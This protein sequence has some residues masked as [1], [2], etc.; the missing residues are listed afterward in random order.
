MRRQVA[1][2]AGGVIG[3][4]SS[5]GGATSGAP[6]PGST[7]ARWATVHAGDL[8]QQA[9]R[10]RGLRIVGGEVGQRRRRAAPVG[11]ADRCRAGRR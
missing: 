3:R 10:R 6:A 2:A 11:R 4:G 9:L 5:A 1:V 8:L 7:P